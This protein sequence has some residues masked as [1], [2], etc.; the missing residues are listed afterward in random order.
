MHLVTRFR[1]RIH[2]IIFINL[3]LLGLNF[4]FR[5]GHLQLF[6]SQN[7]SAL[8]DSWQLLSSANDDIPSP[9]SSEQQTLSLILDIDGDNIND[10]VI[11]SR[12]EPGPALIWYRRGETGWARYIIEPSAL[13]IEAGGAFHDIDGDGDL[14]VVAGCTNQCNSIWWWE[15]P[16]PDFKPATPWTRRL[17]KNSGSNKHHDM[18]FG[19]FDGDPNIELAFWNQGAKQL[20]LV[21]IPPNPKS[22][23]PWPNAVAIYTAPDSQREGLVKA[24]IDLDGKDD[25]IGGGIWFKHINNNNFTAYPIEY[26]KVMRVAV[27]QLVPGGRPEI[28]QIPGDSI[29]PGRWYQWNG[30]AWIGNNLPV[31]TITHGHSLDIGDV[32]Q[33][34]YLDI[35]IGEMRQI[36]TGIDLNANARTMVLYG[37]GQDNFTTDII[38][39]GID[40]HESRLADLDGDGD[41]DILGKPHKWDT[42]RVDVWLNLLGSSIDTPTTTDTPDATSTD[43]DAPDATPTDTETPGA[44]PTNADVPEVTPTDAETPE[45]TPTN[46][47]TATETPT[48]T[49][50]I[51]PTDTSTTLPTST[52]AICFSPDDWASQVIDSARPYRAVF[53]D[54]AD[55]DGDGYQDIVTGG[56]WYRNPGAAG[57]AWQRFAIGAT[58]NQMAVIDDFDGD[59]LPD[60]LGTKPVAAQP[61]LGNAFVWAHN[62]GGA[63]PATQFEIIDTGVTASHG[64]F[65]QG[66]TVTSFQPGVKEVILS[67]HKESLSRLDALIVPASPITQTWALRQLSTVTQSEEVTAGDIDADGDQDILLGSIWLQNTGD[68]VS[69]NTRTLY[70]TSDKPDRSRLS[71]INND[72]RLDSVIGYEKTG[73]Q[74][75][76]LAWYEA[77]PNPTGLWTEH[78]IA[79]S[80][81]ILAPMSLDTIDIDGDG[82]PDVVVGEHNLANPSQGRVIIYENLNQG[83][84]WVAHIIATGNEHHDGTQFVDIDNDGDQDIIS[85][86]WSED[87][88]LLYKQ[89]SSCVPITV[90][91]PTPTNTPTPTKANTPTATPVPTTPAQCPMTAP[92]NLVTNPDFSDTFNW[93]FFTNGKGAFTTTTQTP[94]QQCAPAAQIAIVTAGTNVQ[95]Y[96]S[97]ITLQPKTTYQFSIAARASANRTV[98]VILGRHNA[99]F[100]NYGLNATIKLTPGWQVFMITFTTKGFSSPVSNGRLRIALEKSDAAGDFFFFDNVVIAPS[101]SIPPT[102]TNTPIATHTPIF[103]ATPSETPTATETG[104]PTNTPTA[105]DTPTST[106]IPSDTPNPS[107]TPTATETSAHTATPTHTPVP[108]APTQAY[109]TA[110]TAASGAYAFTDKPAETSINFTQLLA[111]AGQTRAFD[112]ASLRVV[113]VNSGDT[114]IDSDVPFQF[115]MAANYNAANNGAG[116]LVWLMEGNTPANTTRRYHVY[117]DVTGKGFTAPNFTPL[118]SATDNVPHKGYQSIR[119]VTT[120]GEYFYHKPGGGFA[121]LLDVSGNDW[122]GWSSATGA[123]GDFRGIPNM[124][125]PNDGGYFHPGRT[126]AI[127]TLISQGPL[128]VVFKSTDKNG[129][130]ETLW[131]VF[132]AYARM[133]VMKAPSAKYWFLYEGTPGGLLEPGID[134][135]TRSNGTMTLL[136][137]T[138]KT[139]I[140]GDEWLYFSDPNIGRSL[141]LAH[142]QS[143]SQIDAYTPMGG[144]M[145]VF[146]FGRNGNSRLLNGTGR[147]F[148]IGLVDATAYNTVRPAIYNA[149]KDVSVTIE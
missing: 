85:I 36:Q 147:Q 114:I 101:G 71:D 130:W 2:I 20:F 137:A 45:V 55:L 10:F 132:P 77:S 146:G 9:A 123:A 82:D 42:P 17:I 88:V 140:P 148:T 124:V 128:K 97:G 139:D 118:V 49:P 12:R 50:T 56:W 115:D 104:T 84:S 28:I 133:T 108:G 48:G 19:N 113:E 125:H 16:S 99:P 5:I 44:T 46:T 112:P 21:D 40:N 13:H 73:S 27:G 39:T 23:Q 51:P 37:D 14:D 54:S 25:I 131:E 22:T 105:T 119:L 110:L 121:T 79:G 141:Y 68:G 143:D 11:G 33:D 78:I 109:S 41:L 52:P 80:P 117:Y 100:T 60:I 30:S 93:V 149:Y 106:S 90:T 18:V 3:S 127:T 122:I 64:D 102:S 65:L 53:I 98:K 31:G 95:L 43:A 136:S 63:N 59:G 34:G 47:D 66:I 58:F 92:G 86:S 61:H 8:V 94:Y 32:D 62:L 83:A 72:G 129:K 38:A 144:L 87:K 26:F 120:I 111:A 1:R 89:Q 96:Q 142:H 134:S 74:P 7:V 91:P 69:W 76:K 24:D 15:N 103:T 138:L 107:E 126:T 57:G 35:F 135:Q 75:G 6:K 29:G 145:T 81:D 4:G 70:S 67:W 116:T